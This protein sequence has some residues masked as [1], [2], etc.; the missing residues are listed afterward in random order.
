MTR[1]VLS[2][3]LLLVLCGGTANA[4]L[5]GLLK[6]AKKKLQTKVEQTINKA[7]GL[8]AKDSGL[9][10]DANAG[11]G[12]A[13]LSSVIRTVRD[14]DR[15]EP[16]L[17]AEMPTCGD[18]VF[19]I[20]PELPTVDDMVNGTD[21]FFDFKQLIYQA[22]NL[23]ADGE[24]NLSDDV[25]AEVAAA[26]NARGLTPEKI[27]EMEANANK[28]AEQVKTMTPEQ[29]KEFALKVAAQYRLSP[30][31]RVSTEDA[32]KQLNVMQG[33][34]KVAAEY[35]VLESKIDKVVEEGKQ[36]WKNEFAARA[37]ELV[38]ER[39]KLMWDEIGIDQA[40]NNKIL[41]L[42][43]KG[44]ELQKEFYAK[45]APKY[46]EAVVNAMEYLK[47]DYRKAVSQLPTSAFTEEY[48]VGEM[49]LSTA[50]RLANLDLVFE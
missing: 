37:E 40:T 45:Y 18:E 30:T 14:S 41:E 23:A 9:T 6:Q 7:V 43:K 19:A 3:A 28:M 39:E 17:N 29:Q 16:V 49:Y 48:A 33:A 13:G 27:K 8:E 26:L 4:Q 22:K 1:K 38:A 46:R 15:P 10:E 21:K 31:N 2:L 42:G 20:C 11:K 47:N 5:G 25:E 50:A 36:L 12:N 35:L 44:E 24:E 32:E 34:V